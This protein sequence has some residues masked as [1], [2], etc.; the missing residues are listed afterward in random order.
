MDERT[1]V[2]QA[3]FDRLAE[4]G[5][6]FSVLGDS[7]AYPETL[8]SDIDMAM[9]ERDLELLPRILSRFCRDFGLRLVQLIRHE[10]NALYFVIAWW[11]AAG[12]LC[13]L[14]PDVC[15][16]YRRGGRLL[17]TADELLYGRRQAQ[18]GSGRARNFTV[19]AP[20]VQFI[21]YLTKKIDKQELTCQHGDYL[22]QQWRED[23]DGALR[24]MVRFWPELA[25][26]GLIAQAATVNEWAG[27]REQMPRLRRALRKSIRLSPAEALAE[28]ARLASRVLRPTGMTV[29]FMGPDGAG[30]SSVIE[31]VTALLAPAFR[32][33][34]LF[35]LRPRL[36]ARGRATAVAVPHELPPRGALAS[37]AKLAW[38]IA[39]YVLGYL[40]RVRPTTTRSGLAVFDR[41]FHD[42]LADPLRYRYGAPLGAA[43]AA[44][45]LV[46]APD[47]WVV[48]DT[49][50]P[51]LQSRKQE[52]SPPESEVQRRAYLALATRVGD[53]VVVDAGRS[54]AEVSAEAAQAILVWMEDRVERRHVPPLPDN[55]L[56]ARVLQF[57]CRHRV[58][59]LGKLVR[60]LLNSDIYC[61]IR[62]FIRMP[63]PY[64]IIIHSKSR[65]GSGVTVMQQVTIGGKN[66][67]ENFAP[68]IEDGVYVGAGAK[69][70]GAIRV[71][72]GAVIGANA[73]VTRDVPAYSTVVGANRVLRRM[74]RAGNDDAAEAEAVMA[75]LSSSRRF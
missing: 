75:S 59:V 36:I 69:V 18:D 58:P 15:S 46:P 39:D 47:L 12:G 54:L 38:F 27:V 7:R 35:H 37:L 51:V 63:H 8:A 45:A 66:E 61:P 49:S 4:Q 50:V 30:K 73:V 5:L 33:S 62:S 6:A 20:D 3:L 48:L 11:D 65:I 28:A 57:C 68:H 53:A 55:P 72:R 16:D 74:A 1:A 64:G 31:R 32:R 29:A 43:R 34:R 23:P 25:D 13:F 2:A 41:Y 44:A 24:R 21:Y 56:A 10:R 70:L 60:M 42:L 26:N 40:L 52:V 67:G 71:G 19:P 14:A 9:S 17:L 22:A